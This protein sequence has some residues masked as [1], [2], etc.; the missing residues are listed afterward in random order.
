M[1]SSFKEKPTFSA[2]SKG[3]GFVPAV[4]AHACRAGEL[5]T[6]FGQTFHHLPVSLCNDVA[7]LMLGRAFPSPV[8]QQELVGLLIRCLSS[9][10]VGCLVM[11]HPAWRHPVVS[12]MTRKWETTS[13]FRL[14]SSY[15]PPG[16]TNRV[17]TSL[18]ERKSWRWWSWQDDPA[19]D[20][21]PV[22]TPKASVSP[23]LR[24]TKKKEKQAG[25]GLLQWAVLP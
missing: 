22:G 12:S 23:Q 15:G 24:E 21:G 9:D 5:G 25:I 3:E 16:S 10:L 20:V 6:V 7:W 18:R 2:H 19:T 13:F 11:L 17:K 1:P 14:C 4:R 8:V